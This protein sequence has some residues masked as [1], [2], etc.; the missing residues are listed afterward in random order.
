M[1]LTIYIIYFVVVV[2]LRGGPQSH[3]S[4]YLIIYH[5]RD[6]QIEHNVIRQSAYVLSG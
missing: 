5:T 6:Q 3:A 2:W 4:L 1:G